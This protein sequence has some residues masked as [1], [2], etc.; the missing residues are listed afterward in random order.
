MK[1]ISVKGSDIP[2]EQQVFTMCWNLL[3]DYYFIS[4]DDDD[5]WTELMNR[6]RQVGDME[7]PYKGLAVKV[8]LAVLEYL[9]EASKERKYR[10][11]EVQT[12]AE[13]QNK[14][15]LPDYLQ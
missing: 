8:T 9:E 3:K 2:Q 5:E 1:N 14:D 4:N 6:A 10:Q 7:T 12:A 11:E 13:E 15:E